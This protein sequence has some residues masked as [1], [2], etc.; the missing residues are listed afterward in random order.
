MTKKKKLGGLLGSVWLPLASL[1]LVL[2]LAAP[3]SAAPALPAGGP[4]P[5]S[6][7]IPA[8]ETLVESTSLVLAA[9]ANPKVGST[10]T[11]LLAAG[12]R[13]GQTGAQAFSAS[14]LMVVDEAGVQVEILTT[15]EA[16]PDLIK[17][18]EASGGWYQGHYEDLVQAWVPI[19]SVE[20]I[21]ARPDVLYVREPQRAVP[22]DA[23]AP[24]GPAGVAA[25]TSE[26]VAVSNALAWHSA[27]YTGQG[28]RVAVFDSGFKD[29]TSLLGTELPD[30]VKAYD[31]V[32]D[33]IGTH[34]Y[35]TAA[36]EVVHDMAPAAML[37]LHRIN[38]AVELGQAVDQA[39]ADG[40]KVISMA[41]NWLSDGPGDGT[42]PLASIAAGARSKGILFLN[43]AGNLGLTTWSGTFVERPVDANVYHAWD[44]GTKWIN[45]L[46][47][48][49]G[50]CYLKA[51]GSVIQGSLHWDDWTE[52]Q[53]DYDL[54]LYR[55]PG[56]G[57]TVYLV[58]TS[59][60]P[61]NGGEGQTPEEF[62][63][64]VIPDD[65]SA[66]NC[67]AWAVEKVKADR[68]VCF[69]LITTNASVHLD[70]WT[71]M[72]SLPFPADAPNVMAVAAVD[73]DKPFELQ[74]YSSQGPT[75]GP[76]GTCTGGKVKPEIAA[77]TNVSTE[78]L[79]PKAFTGTAAAAS[80]AAGAAALARGAYPSYSA[81][82]T[83]SFLEGR[84]I[85]MG[86]GG[87]DTMYGSGRLYLGDP[88]ADLEYS[89]WLPIITRLHPTQ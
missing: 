61:Q 82:Q 36:A 59:T 81:A 56:E 64:Y 86:P 23:A 69:R 22:A 79:V 78:T 51:P 3:T 7:Q 73:V 34:S 57:T 89:V 44:G 37:S 72:R 67:Y 15:P 48:G 74:A 85:D 18:I 20:A 8:M 70:E 40:A 19:D 62:V 30:A 87:K 14:H 16:V 66:K 60:N 88:P 52:V 76:G 83:Q 43:S 47:Q 32:G 75:F 17:A 53:Q 2:M 71:E 80:H 50:S 55:W 11:Q 6:I 39:A 10:L 33:G 63:S 9:E 24:S 12:Q 41:L 13:G 21:A 42:G 25:V 29:Y 28:V 26:G 68:N 54:R 49:D 27:G 46:G 77:Y 31:H 4:P 45:F 58:A 1:I 35:G 5:P 84:A 65:V 38:T